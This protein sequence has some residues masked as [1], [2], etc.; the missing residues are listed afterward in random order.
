MLES[1]MA[2]SAGAALGATARWL[3]GEALNDLFPS[4]PPG[5]LIANIIGGYLIGIA[6]SFFALRPDMPATLRLFAVTGFLGALTTF[7]TFSAEIC[8]LL[9]QARYGLAFTGIALH[10]CGSLAAFFLGI[11]TFILCS[12]FLGNQ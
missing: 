11:G 7:S 3:L 10:V 8:K 5:T 9:Q 6:I 4:L 12:K 2:I 1:I